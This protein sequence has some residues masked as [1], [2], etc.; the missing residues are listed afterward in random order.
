MNH[1]EAKQMLMTIASE[2]GI[3]FLEREEIVEEEKETA[4]AGY[5]CGFYDGFQEGIA[6]AMREFKGKKDAC[7]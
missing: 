4:F 6:A 2:N 7:D 3:K 5:C 1:D